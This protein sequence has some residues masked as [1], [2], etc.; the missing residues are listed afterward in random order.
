MQ[1]GNEWSIILPKSSQVR[2]TPPPPPLMETE[3]FII[4]CVCI[5]FFF[6]SLSFFF[7]QQHIFANCGM[8]LCFCNEQVMD[9]RTTRIVTS[10]P[11][12]TLLLAIGSSY[13]PC[14]IS[15][16]FVL[17]QHFAIVQI[18]I[19]FFFF[20]AI[21]TRY[22]CS[23]FHSNDLVM[24]C[25]PSNKHIRPNYMESWGSRFDCLLT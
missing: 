22:L 6:F 1:V 9:G 12:P 16:T 13:L 18:I 20:L 15:T 14:I 11:T 10:L 19:F 4:F 8:F 2:K 24:S 21:C 7:T 3:S 5:F 25:Q 23:H 17:L